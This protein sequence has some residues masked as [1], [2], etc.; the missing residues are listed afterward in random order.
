MNRMSRYLRFQDGVHTLLADRTEVGWYGVPERESKS[1]AIPG[2]G[3][4]TP[5]HL[6][7]NYRNSEAYIKSKERRGVKAASL[8]ETQQAFSRPDMW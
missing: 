3:E 4:Y 8:G 7:H 6:H 5:E 1:M 2:L